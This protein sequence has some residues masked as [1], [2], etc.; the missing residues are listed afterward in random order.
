VT[1]SAALIEQALPLGVD[2]FLTGEIFEQQVH[3]PRESGVA[4][5]AAG[6]HATEFFGV[7]AL[8][9]RLAR[10]LELSHG[11]VDIPNPV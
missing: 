6:H 5:L 8:G 9:E 2:A 3:L 4:C 10:E 7:Q 11:F 1:A